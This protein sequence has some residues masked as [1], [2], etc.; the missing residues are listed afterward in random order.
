MRKS[1]FFQVG[2]LMFIIFLSIQFFSISSFGK[3]R[4]A[5]DLIFESNIDSGWTTINPYLHRFHEDSVTLEL[6]VTKSSICEWG[7]YQLIGKIMEPIGRP[8]DNQVIQYQLLFD[9]VYLLKVDEEGKFFI[10]QESGNY[11]YSYPFTFPIKIKYSI[12]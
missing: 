8:K 4:I 11:N 9:K 2:I 12:R 7:E 10:K 3:K 1:K 5:N 6:L